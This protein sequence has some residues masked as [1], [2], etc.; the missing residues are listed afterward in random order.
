MNVLKHFLRFFKEENYLCGLNLTYASKYC[1][2]SMIWELE[3]GPCKL[4][5]VVMAINKDSVG[6][7]IGGVAMAENYV[8]GGKEVA[9]GAVAGEDDGVGCDIRG[10]SKPGILSST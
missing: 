2:F 4:P 1:M 9:A 3:C 7:R 8:G 5:M 6:G 10:H